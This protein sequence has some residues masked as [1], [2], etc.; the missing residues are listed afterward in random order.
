MSEGV[1]V[2]GDVGQFQPLAQRGEI[3][4][5]PADLV[6]DTQRMHADL[7]RLAECVVA[8]AVE[9]QGIAGLAGGFK[10]GVGQAQGGAGGGVLLEAVVAFDDLDVV[11]VAEACRDL[12]GDA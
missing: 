10:D 8:V 6:A 11:V 3:G 9:D 2:G 1:A 4:G 12:A 5:V 7:A